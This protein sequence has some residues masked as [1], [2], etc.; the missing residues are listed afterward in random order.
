M[1]PR[2]HKCTS[3]DKCKTCHICIEYEIRNNFTDPS[4]NICFINYGKQIKHIP[5]NKKK[6]NKI[7]HVEK[8]MKNDDYFDDTKSDDNR[9][10]ISI[11]D[12]Y[13][14][15]ADNFFVKI[16]DN[17]L[18]YSIGDT[19]KIKGMGMNVTNNKILIEPMNVLNLSYSE[20]LALGHEICSNIFDVSNGYIKSSP[21]LHKIKIKNIKFSKPFDHDIFIYNIDGENMRKITKLINEIINENEYIV[22]ELKNNEKK[23]VVINIFYVFVD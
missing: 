9:D 13:F 15:D 7:K 5:K 3:C 4:K 11:G 12:S 21:I 1:P 23:I 19:I 22:L 8:K 14:N 18:E 17:K 20:D 2:F 10:F 6:I 16:N